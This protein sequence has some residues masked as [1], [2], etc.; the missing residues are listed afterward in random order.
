M[1]PLATLLTKLGLDASEF[2]KG[3]DDA[4]KAADT[5]AGGIVKSL[6]GI[7]AGI[8]GGIAAGV[9]VVGGAILG[10]LV[11]ATKAASEAQVVEAQLDAVLK[12]TGG[13]A[14]MNRDELLGMASALMKT[15]R[16]EDDAIIAGENIMLTFTNIG[17]EVFPQATETML[18]MATALGTDAPGAAQLLGKALNDPIMG[19]TSL[20]RVGVQFT[21]EQEEMIKTMM[22]AGDVAGAQA[23]ILDKLGTSFGGSAVA[24]GNTFA[25]M[26]DRVKN[27]GGQLMEDIGTKIL[28]LLETLGTKLMEWLGSPAVQAAIDTLVEGI[29]TIATKVEEVVGFLMEGDIAGAMSAAFGPETGAKIMGVVDKLSSFISTVSTFVSEHSEAFK[30]AL[31]GIAVAL[32]VAAVAAGIMSISIS[33]IVLPILAII[34]VAALLGAAWATNWGGIQDKTKAVV[35][36]ITVLV[37]GFLAAVKGFWSDHGEDIMAKAQEIWDKVAEVFTFFKDQFMRVFDAFKLLFQGDF[38]GFGEKLREYWDAAWLAI[39]NI[40]SDTWEAIKKF[41]TETDWGAVGKSILEGIARGITTGASLIANAAMNAARAAWEAVKG[42][43]GIG[44]PSKLFEKTVGVPIGEGWALGIEKSMAAFSKFGLPRIAKATTALGGEHV[45]GYRLE[46]SAERI[47]SATKAC[48]QVNNYFGV[49]SVRSEEDIYR[50]SE[51][52]YRSLE[53]RGLQKAI[54]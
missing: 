39:R 41:F 40:G 31:M 2:H 18:D 17:K 38:R 12:S 21:D 45:H 47:R 23:I 53:V 49:D 29:G 8:A 20:R 3:L 48:C 7:G 35:D 19:L 10:G 26:L 36:F 46:E 54:G 27:M 13:A 37:K 6:G 14:G 16:Y 42:F 25:G 24:A 52:I 5:S 4:S 9:A 50:L 33:P 44:S 11:M 43:F 22:E 32:G 28:P 34:A 30:G 15:T 1:G 51:Q